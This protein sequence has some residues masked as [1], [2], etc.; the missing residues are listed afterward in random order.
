V[1][2]P[3]RARPAGPGRKLRVSWPAAAC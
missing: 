2:R 3:C 1:R